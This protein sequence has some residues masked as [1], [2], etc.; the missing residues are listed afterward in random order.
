ME[1]KIIHIRLV[2]GSASNR[3]VAIQQSKCSLCCEDNKTKKK[4]KKRNKKGTFLKK[5]FY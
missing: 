4:K 3:L 2:T 5:F 1:L